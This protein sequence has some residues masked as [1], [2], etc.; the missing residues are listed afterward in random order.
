M[1]KLLKVFCA[2]VLLQSSCKT[3][4]DLL[5]P[6]KETMVIYGLLD[7]SDS[8]QVLRINRA[9]LGEGDAYTFAQVPDSFNYRDILD[10]K[11]ERY[12]KDSVKTGTI[13]LERF[14]GPPLS[15]GIFATQ[16]NILYRT[17]GADSIYQDDGGEYKMIVY[18]RESGLTTVSRTEVVNKISLFESPSSGGSVDLV[19]NPFVIKWNAGNNAKFYDV[20]I[21]FHYRE[22]EKANT[23]NIQDK[24]VEWQVGTAVDNINSSSNPLLTIP[25][26]KESFYGSVRRSIN[27]DNA[28]DRYFL[29]MD[30]LY[31]GGTS[32]LYTYIQVNKPPTG[33]VQS[34]PD[35]S[36]IEDGVGIFSSRFSQ[37]LKSKQLSPA[38][39]DTLAN[40]YLT[41]DL[42]FKN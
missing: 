28:V 27:P 32:D 7:P 41:G 8:V 9:F 42:G 20:Y 33:I 14:E 21:R 37:I 6:Y 24:T 26:S 10:V 3:D 30:F 1:N 16:P 17:T 2:I 35:F 25:L 40:G 4:I 5:A 13:T 34:I 29:G 38:S 18:N 15:S 31:Y 11:L 22:I 19:G 23:S 36:N 12:N 39:K